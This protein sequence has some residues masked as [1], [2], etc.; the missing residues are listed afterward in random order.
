M[1]IENHV[2]ITGV[3]KGQQYVIRVEAVNEAG[4][5]EFAQTEEAITPENISCSFCR[6]EERSHKSPTPSG[7]PERG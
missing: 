3:K 7:G 6:S 1:V 2:T 5:G 4:R